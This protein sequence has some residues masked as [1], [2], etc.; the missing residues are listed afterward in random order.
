MIEVNLHCTFCQESMTTKVS[1]DGWQVR[2][3]AIEDEDAL[4][5]AHAKV[6]DF[7]KDQCPGCVA[8]WP[9]CPLYRSFANSRSRDISENELLVIRS[10]VCPRRVNGSFMVQASPFKIT[11]VNISSVSEHGAALEQAIRGYIAKYPKETA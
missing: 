2:Y 7:F 11:D 6:E 5:P 8:G 10:G 4:C 9:E 1:A 3:G